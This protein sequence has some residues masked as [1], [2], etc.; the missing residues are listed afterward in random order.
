MKMTMEEIID[1][2]GTED[3]AIQYLIDNGI[4]QINQKCTK[5]RTKMKFNFERRMVFCMKKKCRQ[6]RSIFKNTFFSS[7]RMGIHKLLQACYLYLLKIEIKSIMILTGISSKTISDWLGFVRQLVGEDVSLE[8][9]QIGG[10]DIVVEI[11]ETKMG[12]RKYHRGHSVEGVWVV[13]GVERT[14]EKKMFAVEV[15]NRDAETISEI[16]KTYVKE[17]SVINTDCWRAYKKACEVNGFEH[18]TVNHSETFKNPLDGTHTNT[19]EGNNNALKTL[20]RPRNRNKKN[21]K[22]YLLYFIWRRLNKKNLWTGFL[23]ALK[24][25]KY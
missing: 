18:R 22:Y 4:V 1:L 2:W 14:E 7:A 9:T 16:I 6:S 12:R 15:E 13:A 5:C 24:N 21:I 23:S 17:G 8:E 3:K 19:I 25:I 10:P 20:I 11:D